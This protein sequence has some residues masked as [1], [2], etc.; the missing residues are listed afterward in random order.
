MTGQGV[1][2]DHAPH[3]PSTGQGGSPGQGSLLVSL[4]GQG[5]PG[6]SR[7]GSG[8][9]QRRR[10]L[11]TGTGTAPD[12]RHEPEHGPHDPH[13]PHAP[14]T[15]HTATVPWHCR[16]SSLSPG[17]QDPPQVGE[18]SEQ[19]RWRRWDPPPPQVTEQG[20]Q[21]DH[22]DHEPATGQQPVSHALSCHSVLFPGCPPGRRLRPL[23]CVPSP[24]V[25]E[26][27]LQGSHGPQAPARQGRQW[28]WGRSL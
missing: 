19:L 12:P 22:G 27:P 2:G 10:R 3:A 16:V 8:E 13:G 5:V 1:A 7:D 25:T 6:G 9:S 17:P 26:Q 24:H 23:L 11:R 20:P 18:G 14:G 21:G 28:A 15:G 4:P